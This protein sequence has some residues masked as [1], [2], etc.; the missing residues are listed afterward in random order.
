MFPIVK[1]TLPPDPRLYS[2]L[3]MCVHVFRQ[4]HTHICIYIHNYQINKKLGIVVTPFTL[5]LW[6]LR[7]KIFEFKFSLSYL[8]KYQLLKKIDKK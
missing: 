1:G 8:V 6:R 5:V 4:T 3:H 2:G 7:Q